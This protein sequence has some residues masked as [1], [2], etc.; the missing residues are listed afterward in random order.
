MF[1]GFVGNFYGTL[2][3]LWGTLSVFYGNL[4]IFKVDHNKNR[5][6]RRLKRRLTMTI[7]DGKPLL[8]FPSCSLLLDLLAGQ[9]GLWFFFR[10]HFAGKVVFAPSNN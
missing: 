8:F 3:D 6:S 4:R 10:F 7:R 9:F 5:L 1:K 2:R